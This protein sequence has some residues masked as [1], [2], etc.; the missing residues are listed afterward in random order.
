MTQ[1]QATKDSIQK[2][3]IAPVNI[4]VIKYW[5]KRD[6]E[7]ILPT[8]SSLSVTLDTADLHTRTTVHVSPEFDGDKFW[9]NGVEEA[10]NKRMKT[11]LNEARSRRREL[12]N[13]APRESSVHG[14]P[15]SE[16]S[17]HIAS[18]NNFPTAAGLASSASGLACLAST[19]A[20]VYGLIDEKNEMAIQRSWTS[21]SQ[22]A[23]IG[24]GSACRSIFGGFVEWVMGG[25]SDGS[26]SMAVQVA[27]KAHWPEMRALI[28]VANDEKKEVSSTSGM[29]TTVETSTLFKHRL[30]EVVDT[31]TEEIKDAIK[32]KDFAKFAEITM[33]DSN[34]F[35]SVCLDTYPPI[36]YLNATSK[37]IIRFVHL[38]NEAL[39][40][41]ALCYT[42]DAG[43]NAVLYFIEKD[44]ELVSG[45]IACM[46]E[47]VPGI[48][49]PQVKK[50]FSGDIPVQSNEIADS[51]RGKM[52]KIPPGGVKRI[53]STRVG[54]GPQLVSESLLDQSG[55]PILK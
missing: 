51:M 30:R 54:D 39:G 27:P 23:R 37:L 17:V 22:L 42:F 38:F 48:D 4:A 31:R 2:T 34:Q 33:L 5:G 11:V 24:S 25:S 8:N 26:D 43:P 10:L 32:N 29:Q 1:T 9:L 28:L 7:L 6:T 44:F 3:C 14:K 45:T 55:Y 41:I 12:E 52:R 36:F 40:R 15:I 53:I 19:L 35:H 21:V 13:S 20:Y 47:E 18:M 46:L 50:I 16:W 49:S